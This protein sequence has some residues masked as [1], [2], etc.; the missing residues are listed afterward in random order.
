[1]SAATA[2]IIAFLLGA[3]IGAGWCWW[4]VDAF[5]G[6]TSAHRLWR[7]ITWFPLEVLCPI[8]ELIT[9]PFRSDP[10]LAHGWAVF[11]ALALMFAIG[12]LIVVGIIR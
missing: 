4:K 8:G 12:V 2:F 6:I 9:R 11:N 10:Y 7:A 5:S 3:W 1:M